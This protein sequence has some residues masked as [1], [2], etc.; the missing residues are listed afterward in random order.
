MKTPVTPFIVG[1]KL[2]IPILSFLL[3]TGSLSA[4][5]NNRRN[6]NQP[7]QAQ[8]P[9]TRLPG[10]APDGYEV[11]S[12]TGSNGSTI[13]YSL[14]VPEVMVPGEKYPLVLC[15]HGSRGATYAAEAMAAPELRKKHPC[16]VMA[17][18]APRTKFWSLGGIP[19]HV[20]PEQLKERGMDKLD[21]VEVELMEALED[22]VANHAVDP[23]RLYITGQSKG[24]HGTWGTILKNPNRFAAAAP[25][26]GPVGTVDVTS[27][28]HLPDFSWQCRSD[29]RRGNFSS[30]GRSPEKGRCFSGLHRISRS[31]SFQLGARL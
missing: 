9:N 12:F 2:V 25:I 31:R 21:S 13:R 4:Q 29:R 23:D 15:L 3:F 16:F 18:A 26:C 1:L 14:L 8:S 19:D 27:I 24:G 6:S 7:S 30:H 20:T 11:K 10:G 28:A 17:P 5:Q 22:V